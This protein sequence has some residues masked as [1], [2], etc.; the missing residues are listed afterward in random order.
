MDKKRLQKLAGLIPLNEGSKGFY[1]VAMGEGEALGLLG[2]FNN[3]GH[4]IAFYNKHSDEIGEYQYETM[5]AMSPAEW[6]LTHRDDN[7]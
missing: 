7:N 1:A 3:Q 5:Y 6:I 2:P 4:W